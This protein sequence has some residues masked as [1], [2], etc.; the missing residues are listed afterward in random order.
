MTSY[1][2]NPVSNLDKLYCSMTYNV[3]DKWVTGLLL[4]CFENWS[5][6]VL[7]WK[8]MRHLLSW[9][10][11]KELTSINTKEIQSLRWLPTLHLRMETL[12]VSE[13]LYSLE[14]EAMDK[15]Q[16]WIIQNDIHRSQYKLTRMYHGPV[17]ELPHKGFTLLSKKF[18]SFLFFFA[19]ENIGNFG[20]YMNMQVRKYMHRVTILVQLL[21]K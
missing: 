15:A 8:G 9:A 10:R 18:F 6:S 5:A 7:K 4:Q 3:Q 2:E 13:T 12:L 16:N 1:N 14:Y 17:H 20:I 21:R 19:V 11:Y